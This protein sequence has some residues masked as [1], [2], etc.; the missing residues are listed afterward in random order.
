MQLSSKGDDCLQSVGLDTEG[1][2]VFQHMHTWRVLI[3]PNE[4]LVARSS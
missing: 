4:F 2:T 3:N 1:G